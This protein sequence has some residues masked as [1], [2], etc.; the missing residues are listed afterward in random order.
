MPSHTLEQF[1][2]TRIEGDAAIDA[3][4][5]VYLDAD[6][7][8]DTSE[9]LV[10]VYCGRFFLEQ[11]AGRFHV[12]AWGSWRSFSRIEQ[13]EAYLYELAVQEDMLETPEE[14]LRRRYRENCEEAA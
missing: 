8:F 3:L 9:V 11:I 4:R 6:R 5:E 13:A 7:M 2:A 14:T 12:D 1:R 10:H